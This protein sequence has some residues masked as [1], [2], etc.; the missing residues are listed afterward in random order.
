MNAPLNP[1]AMQ[2]LLANQ[3]APTWTVTFTAPAMLQECP[4]EGAAFETRADAYE[5][6]GYTLEKV[7]ELAF[8]PTKGM[9]ISPS[10]GDCFY[11][12]SDVFWNGD[13][14]QD[15]FVRLKPLKRGPELHREDL[16]RAH[17]WQTEGTHYEAEQKR[18][19]E[20][21]QAA[22]TESVWEAIAFEEVDADNARRRVIGS[23]L[24]KLEA[25]LTIKTALDAGQCVAATVRH[26]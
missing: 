23:G 25:E 8:M 6:T 2:N 12:V 24:T 22:E 15:L 18:K 13:K 11:V 19:Q 20:K 9:I 1:L 3:T 5:V 21:L 4:R 7:M 10:V 17:G 16:M 26:A 14:P